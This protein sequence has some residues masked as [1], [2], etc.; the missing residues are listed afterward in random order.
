[1]TSGR[2]SRG[3][4]ELSRGAPRGCGCWS[5]NGRRRRSERDAETATRTAGTNATV[6]VGKTGNRGST[7]RLRDPRRA[8]SI[9]SDVGGT[10][11]TSIDRHHVGKGQEDRFVALLLFS[12]LV[13]RSVICFARVIRLRLFAFSPIFTPIQLS[14]VA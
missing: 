7:E 6:Y 3:Q 8:Q 12:C 1:M 4:V 14:R 5:R 2:W 13:L 11:A 9:D 10:P